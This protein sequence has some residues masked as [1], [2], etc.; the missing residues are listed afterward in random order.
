[1]APRFIG[2]TPLAGLQPIML[3]GAPVLGA[4]AQLRDLLQRRAGVAAAALFAEPVVTWGTADQPGSVS[5]YADLPGDAEPLSALPPD[6][7]TGP[8]SRLRDTMRGL[9]PL[10]DD[11]ELG[12][13]LRRAL[14]VAQAGSIL[15]VGGAPL[16]TDWGLSA[17]AGGTEEEQA[18]RGRAWAAAY[19]TMPESR[20][21][22]PIAPLA[23]PPPPTPPPL[24]AAPPPR[25]APMPANR[26]AWDWALAPAALAVAG[27]FLGIGL[28]A[29]AR[30]VAARIAERPTAVNLL[31]ERA[32]REA[33]DRQ[34][35]QN[36][37]LEREIEARRRLLA[38]N[39]CVPDP[40]QMPQLGPNRAAPVP[41]GSVTP[42]SGGQAFQGSL[43]ELLTQAVVLIIAPGTDGTSTGTGFFIAPDLI[44]TNRHVIES[45][46]QNAIVVT[47][48]KLGRTTRVRV[49]AQ[50]PN[51]EIGSPDVALLKVEGIQGIQPL[52]FTL[53][54]NPLDQVIAAGFPG[55][56]L[57]SDEAFE[58][59]KNGDQS[60][61]PEVIL[62]DGRINAIQS[63][64]SGMKIMPHSAAVSGG[65]SGGPLVDACGRVL[66]INTFITANREQVVHA[67]YAQKTDG[68][69]AFI[70]ES[71]TP[72]ADATGPCA[73]GGPPSAAP[74]TP[75]L[76]T[77]TPAPAPAPAPATPAPATPAPATP[78]T[79][80]PAT[81][82]PAAP[83]P[84]APA[85]PVPAT[86]A[87]AAPA[88]NP[89][90]VVTPTPPAPPTP[91]PATPA[92][93]PAGG[94]GGKP[95]PAETR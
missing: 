73:P 9:T 88:P 22:I 3:D 30:M 29:G 70:R 56:L 26:S 54:A 89:P 16:L 80:A 58:R 94:G 50:T 51:S 41:P 13:L 4:Y 68:V 19:L 79:P 2:K 36:A 90:A 33:V 42:P 10:M 34:R 75:G 1:M 62:T 72:V 46:D 95:P 82:A 77:P 47:S 37:A 23:S 44:A 24:L 53:V 59:L 27:L 45:A 86:P 17:Q 21:P 84:P 91:A 61:V 60:A 35:E 14:A 18:A 83:V 40:A 92:V 32:A 8:E 69:I 64:P 66:G 39:V 85:T 15:A 38:G 81:P 28:W 11:G 76:A 48:K 12:P 6:R 57:Q 20:A 5:W 55:L 63:A 49:V 52:S 7:R 93:P 31:D 71:G 67:N 74:S 65:N 25:L 87:P 78:A 43:A